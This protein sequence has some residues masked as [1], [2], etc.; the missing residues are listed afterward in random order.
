[1]VRHRL[2]LSESFR[3]LPGRWI[4]QLGNAGNKPAD[5][6]Q[7]RKRSPSG[8]IAYL[9]GLC[10]YLLFIVGISLPAGNSQGFLIIWFKPL[11]S[12]SRMIS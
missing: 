1:M 10:G 9:D 6:Y 4:C 7:V 2:T 12:A 3:L 5:K 11:N 8:Y